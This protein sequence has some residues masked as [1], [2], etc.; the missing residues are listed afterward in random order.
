M[1]RALVLVDVWN[2]REFEGDGPWGYRLPDSAGVEPPEVPAPVPGVAIAGDPAV[3]PDLLGPEVIPPIELPPGE[4]GMFTPLS[5]E[6][7]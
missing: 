3:D 4:D 1:Q 6:G 2:D 7:D 5:P